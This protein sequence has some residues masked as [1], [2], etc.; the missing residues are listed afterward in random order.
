MK[1]YHFKTLVQTAISITFLQFI[2]LQASKAADVS[3][4]GSANLYPAEILQISDDPNIK[5]SVMTADKAKRILKFYTPD[6]SL[7]ES[8][9]FEIDIG[10]N[11]GNKTK[12]DDKK[13][14]E[15]IYVL[16]KKLLP[17]EIPFDLY[18]SMA[19][20]TNYPNVFDKFENKTGSG[21]WLHSVP[22]TIPLS[23]GSKGCVVL[24]NNVIQKLSSAIE[25]NKS[26]LIINDKTNQ[27]DEN[28][29]QK[30]KDKVVS[31]IEL[32]RATWETQEL[33][34]Y[35][36]LYDD[37]FSAP[38]FNKG[39]WLKHKEK[40]KGIYQNIKIDLSK[41]SIFHIKNQYLVK[42]LQKYSSSGHQD[43]GVKMLYLIEEK[44]GFKIIR[45]EWEAVNPS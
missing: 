35:I 42:V 38:G 11:S 43:I 32:W 20:T 29:H 30:Q 15:G 19:F 17:P 7:L 39:S 28:E 18:G 33:D 3:T 1:M 4:T 8:E 13:T 21:I 6:K 37:D 26:F 16:Q 22:D 10:K 40:L 24:R 31:W 25:L 12:R 27:I 41:A 5:A 36:K 14:P 34:K 2:T 44:N 45:E 23:R 9:V